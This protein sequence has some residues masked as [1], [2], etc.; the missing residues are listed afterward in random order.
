MKQMI[1]KL[2]KFSVI[3]LVILALVGLVFGL[4]T[5]IGWSWW[6]GFFILLGLVGLALGFVLLRKIFIR[7][8]ERRFV[9]QVI[10]QDDAYRTTLDDKE[11]EGAKQLQEK[12]KEAM[13]ALR[14]SRLRKYGN[15]L[16]V[17]PWYLVIGE[18]GSGKTTAIQSAGLSSPLLE[19]TRTP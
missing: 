7:R 12:W 13:A 4:V 16:Y 14:T 19:Y 11:K 18:S 10:E 17:L 6:V 5:G 1:W 8:R 2:I 9:Q 3:A 15:P